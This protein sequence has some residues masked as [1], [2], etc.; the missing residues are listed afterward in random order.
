M[1]VHE[2]LLQF[3]V[4]ITMDWNWKLSRWNAY[5]ICSVCL[6][7]VLL[8]WCFFWFLP[9]SFT[10]FLVRMICMH[11]KA[12]SFYTQPN[13]NSNSKLGKFCMRSHTAMRSQFICWCCRCFCDDDGG[14]GFVGFWYWKALFLL[15]SKVKRSNS[16]ICALPLK[17]S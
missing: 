14:C 10:F 1:G 4:G 16:I 12:N 8:S 15:S 9:G 2:N 5:F 17:Q 3:I 13:S 7:Y 11:N 6:E